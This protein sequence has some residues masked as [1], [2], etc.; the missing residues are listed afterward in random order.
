MLVNDVPGNGLY[1]AAVDA[2][3]RSLYTVSEFIVAVSFGR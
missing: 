3:G 2:T 1:G